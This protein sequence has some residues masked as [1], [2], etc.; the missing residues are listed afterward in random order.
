MTYDVG[1][2]NPCLGQVQKCGGVKPV[3]EI[4]TLSS[5]KLDHIYI[6]YSYPT[7]NIDNRDG[8]Y[9]SPLLI[10]PLQLKATSLI[11]PDFRCTEIE[12]YYLIW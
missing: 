1:N 6:Y 4:P 3:N 10:R 12:K 2:P 5:W 9:C 11:R 7:V 8:I